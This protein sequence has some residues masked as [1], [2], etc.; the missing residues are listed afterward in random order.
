MTGACLVCA[1]AL[2]LEACRGGQRCWLCLFRTGAGSVT[3]S[4]CGT[5]VDVLRTEE[6]EG[7]EGGAVLAVW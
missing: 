5:F 3:G 1:M 2:E 4:V 7:A 6:A